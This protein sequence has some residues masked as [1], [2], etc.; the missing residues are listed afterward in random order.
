MAGETRACGTLRFCFAKPQSRASP[1][2]KSSKHSKNCKPFF[3]CPYDFRHGSCLTRKNKSPLHTVCVQRANVSRY[4]LFL[5]K[6][7]ML[8]LKRIFTH[9]KI[10]KQLRIFPSVTG[11][12]VITYPSF[13]FSDPVQKLPSV[14]SI[15]DDLSAGGSSSLTASENVLLFLITFSYIPAILAETHYFVKPK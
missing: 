9:G 5:R 1:Y 12:P 11:S 10:D 2:Q 4:H 6:P 8:C 15:P 13:D 3:G 14:S 7:L